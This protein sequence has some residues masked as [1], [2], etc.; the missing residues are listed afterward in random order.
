MEFGHVVAPPRDDIVVDDDDDDD[1]DE[2][3]R[4][5]VPLPSS[6]DAIASA[7][8]T[9]GAPAVITAR[10]LVPRTPLNASAVANVP[11]CEKPTIAS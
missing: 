5:L 7:S 1:I 9:Q 8:S 6:S 2:N 11:P 4:S 3:A 10:S